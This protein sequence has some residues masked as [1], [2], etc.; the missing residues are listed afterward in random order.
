MS[1]LTE[2]FRTDHVARPH[3]LAFWNDVAASTFGDIAV[4]ARA[5]VFSAQLK[6]LRLGALTLASIASSPAHVSGALTASKAGAGWFLL[7]N[8][9]GVTR[10]SQGDRAV[11][12]Q[13]GELTALRAD[14]RYRIEFSEPN[15]TVVLHMPGEARD[16]DLDPHIARKHGS[17][18]APL[19]IALLRQLLR[20]DSGVEPSRFERLALEVARVCWPMPVRAKPRGSILMWER[21]VLDYVEQ[22]LRDPALD[23]HSI[24]ARFGITARF[25]HMIFARAG[26][27]AGT[28]I[29]ERR[30][31]LAAARLRAEPAERI[32]TIAFDAGFSELSHFCRAFRRHFGVSARDY[33]QTSLPD[34]SASPRIK[35]EHLIGP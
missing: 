29:L 2:T 31:A 22:N 9:R 4:D 24:A 33:R 10:M 35:T 6:R 11:R 32:T 27:T 19:F 30:L 5:G 34:N 23:A 7:L 20:V 3:R 8:E 28:F 16:I 13:P 21:R 26:R 18:E 1:P 25:V 17:N 15:E 12:L 14:E